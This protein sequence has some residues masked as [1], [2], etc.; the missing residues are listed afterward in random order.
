MIS[1]FPKVC[2]C[3]STQA[4]SP[5]CLNLFASNLP[6]GTD[7]TCYHRQYQQIYQHPCTIE[8]F[9]YQALQQSQGNYRSTIHLSTEAQSDLHWW[10]HD[11][12]RSL[13][14]S[15]H[16][17]TNSKPSDNF[18]CL[19]DRLGSDMPGDPHWRFMGSTGKSRAHQPPGTQSSFP[20]TT[21][22]CL[23]SFKDCTSY[24]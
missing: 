7:N 18:G 17:F 4:I 21:D 22:L 8:P 13:Q 15:P 23:T 14:W 11:A 12:P 1:E 16:L 20:R 2:K 3:S 5:P 19:Q 9:G 24:F 6:T 10:I